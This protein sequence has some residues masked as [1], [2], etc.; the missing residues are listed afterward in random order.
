L[1]RWPSLVVLV[2]LA[3][4]ASLALTAPV[5]AEDDTTRPVLKLSDPDFIK[6]SSL[7]DTIVVPG[8]PAEQVQMVANWTATDS[9]GV[10]GTRYNLYYDGAPPGRWSE[11][12]SQTSMMYWAWYPRADQSP[13]QLSV[14]AIDCAGNKSRIQSTVFA[15][16]IVQDDQAAYDGTWGISTC[17]CWSG[18]TTHRTYSAGAKATFDIPSA[19]RVA[20]VMEQ[21]PD[22]GKARIWLDGLVAGRVDTYAAAK[23]HRTVVWTRRLSA[24]QHTLTI[25]NLGTS[26]RSRIDVDAV[27]ISPPWYG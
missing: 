12:N 10:C 25:E 9:S 2:G 5:S 11:W 8:D 4:A 26:G 14:Q 20:V 23:Q 1:Y 16:D 15:M 3:S 24:G 21:A 18:G 17:E 19:K 6:G 7:T 27:L 13:E 22:R